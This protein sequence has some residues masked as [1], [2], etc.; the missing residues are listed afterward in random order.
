MASELHR[1]L[2]ARRFSELS[3]VDGIGPAGKPAGAAEAD[4]KQ[5]A[6][7]VRQSYATRYARQH[8]GGKENQQRL[9]LEEISER[10]GLS[11]LV[12]SVVLPLSVFWWRRCCIGC[13]RCG[14][15]TRAS[16]VAIPLAVKGQVVQGQAIAGVPG[17]RKPQGA[18]VYDPRVSDLT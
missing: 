1:K 12:Y 11:E 5:H 10:K 16:H 7:R 18:L 4:A 14:F 6:P 9:P 3:L 2:M 13:V 17:K 15:V 8:G